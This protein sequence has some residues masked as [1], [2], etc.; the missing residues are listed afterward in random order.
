M[1]SA[2]AIIEQLGLTAHPEGGWYKETWRA[3]SDSSGRARGTAIVFLLKQGEAS[4]WH[5]V[6]ADEMWI[7]QGGD[8]L[9]LGIASSNSGPTETLRLGGDVLADEMLQG[10]VPKNSWQAASPIEDGPLGYSLVSCIVVP[11]FDF[12]G[13]EL[14]PPGWAPGKESMA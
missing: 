13:F 12:A 6:D 3:D 14:A 9:E 1:N 10:L 2:D 11:G 7:W 4:H 8:A 5:K